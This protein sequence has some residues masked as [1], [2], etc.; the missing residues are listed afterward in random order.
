MRARILFGR[1]DFGWGNGLKPIVWRDG[2]NVGKRASAD[3][4]YDV[5]WTLS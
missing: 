5:G 1:D 4:P 2:E 3:C